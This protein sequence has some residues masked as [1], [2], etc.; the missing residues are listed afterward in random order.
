MTIARQF[1]AA[2]LYLVTRRTERRHH[3]FRPDPVMSQIFL[4]CLGYAA[5]RSGVRLFVACLLSNHYHVAIADPLGAAPLFTEVLN[6]FLTKCTQAH[7]GWMGR[8]FDGQG[9][10]YVEL[11]TDDSVVAELAYTLAN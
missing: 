4:Y 2:T 10:S 7:R 6:Y 8:V 11:L 5:L 1:L 3:P 9:P